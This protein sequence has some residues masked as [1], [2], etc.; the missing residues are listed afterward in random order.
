VELSELFI[1]LEDDPLTLEKSL[2]KKAKEFLVKNELDA[3][4]KTLL[5]FNN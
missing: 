1:E 5:S 4:W 3:A 2:H